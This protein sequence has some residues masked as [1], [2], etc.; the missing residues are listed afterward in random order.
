MAK[1]KIIIFDSSTLITLSMNGLLG[2]LSGLKKNFNGKFI[3][4]PAVKFET[5]DRPLNLKRFELGA[6]EI[7]ELVKEK[8]I[9]MPDSIKISN[10]ELEQKTV[11]IMEFVNQIFFSQDR[12]IHLI[13]RGEA[14]CLAI[15]EILKDKYDVIIAVDER[16]TR[17]LVERPE[18]LH[19]LFQK[20]LHTDIKLAKADFD[21]FKD[22][23]IIRSSE[24]A[25]VAYNKGLIKL[26]ADKKQVLDALLYAT[27]FKGCAIS[28]EEIEEVLAMEK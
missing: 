27:K 8:I 9:E 18:N 16:T 5:I 20:K 1:Q 15:A 24:L 4:T 2:M 19:K 21:R 3:M 14:S 23:K 7:L 17:V 26:E 12:F 6:L 11:E 22:I 25:Y 10:E 13:D 28:R